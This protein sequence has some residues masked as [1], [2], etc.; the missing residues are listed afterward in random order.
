MTFSSAISVMCTTKEGALTSLTKPGESKHSETP[1]WKRRAP[2]GL[3][4]L[5]LKLVPILKNNLGQPSTLWKWKA[6]QWIGATA[7]HLPWAMA[8]ANRLTLASFYR[9]SY[10]LGGLLGRARP[11]CHCEKP[12]QPHPFFPEEG[13]LYTASGLFRTGNPNAQTLEPTPTFAN[14]GLTE[15][16]RHSSG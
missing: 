1:P 6:G 14:P 10:R 16:S 3:L 5:P 7:S 9:P 8:T 4:W 15:P 12:P 11:P 13:A 2:L